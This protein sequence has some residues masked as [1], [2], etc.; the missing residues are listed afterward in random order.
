MR[1]VTLPFLVTSRHVP[2][3]AP[4]RLHETSNNAGWARAWETLQLH[5][6]TACGGRLG[7]A[8]VLAKAAAD[9]IVCQRM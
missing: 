3:G 5:W 6:R 4:L 1:G 8:A 2:A 9:G 7:A